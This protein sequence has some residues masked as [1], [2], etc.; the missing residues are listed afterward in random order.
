MMWRTAFHH[1][2]SHAKPRSIQLGKTFGPLPLQKLF[3]PFGHSLAHWLRVNPSNNVTHSPRTFINNSWNRSSSRRR[4]RRNQNLHTPRPTWQSSR[5]AMKRV[6]RMILH[7][8]QPYIAVLVAST[9]LNQ[10]SN[11]RVLSNYH[12]SSCVVVSRTT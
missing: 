5:R 4:K 3:T 9:R 10:V 11:R 1:S 2:S 7:A 8:H 12:S 6:K